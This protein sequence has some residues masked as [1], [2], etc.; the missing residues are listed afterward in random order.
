[1]QEH[2]VPQNITSYEFHLIGSMT[3]K[4]FFEL[5]IGGGL[6]FASYSSNLPFIFKWPL[7]LTFVFL[8]IAMAFI[9]VEERPL[10]KWIVAFFKA[11]Y[12]PTKFFWKK[13]IKVPEIFLEEEYVAVTAEPTVEP[14][15]PQQRRARVQDYVTSI[16]ASQQ[17]GGEDLLFQQYQLQ[18]LQIQDLFTQ[19]APAQGITSTPKAI[20]D[21]YGVHPSLQVKTH[22][23]SGTF[24]LPEQK[25]AKAEESIQEVQKTR[26]KPVTIPVIEPLHVEAQAVPQPQPIA[27]EQT[28]PQVSPLQTTPAYVTSSTGQA[29]SS[30]KT[31]VS[32]PFPQKPTVPNLIVGMVLDNT[33]NILDNTI[34]EIRSMDGIPVR[35]M[36]T[37]MLGQF[38][39]S[40]PLRTGKYQIE[41]EKEGHHFDVYTLDLQNTIID[42]LEI[43]AKD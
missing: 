14:I 26:I 34:I 27:E 42:P 10:D 4:Q 24:I 20:E 32:L 41:A 18:A 29:V 21:E 6:A 22:K 11:I 23:L 31:N 25:K 17:P 1:M 13:E 9:P 33:G 8:G 39:I 12:K 35:A 7:V 15:N 40:N 16:S 3:V 19:V 2:P 38:S 5:L 30:A 36:K 28:A 43:R 37:N